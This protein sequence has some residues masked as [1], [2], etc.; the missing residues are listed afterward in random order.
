MKVQQNVSLLKH[1]CKFPCLESPKCARAVVKAYYSMPFLSYFILSFILGLRFLFGK[2]QFNFP[3]KFSEIND[4]CVKHGTRK[5][6]YNGRRRVVGDL[7]LLLNIQ[8]FAILDI[9]GVARYSGMM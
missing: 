3:Y 8:D 9:I 4:E 7:V 6:K 1:F 2:F 5:H